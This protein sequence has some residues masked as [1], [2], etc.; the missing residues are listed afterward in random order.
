MW[1]RG[2]ALFGVVVW[3]V[4]ALGSLLTGV[5]TQTAATYGAIALFAA[6]ALGLG[7]FFER[8]TA[9]LLGASAVALVALGAFSGWEFGVW[10][11]ISL[12]LILPLVIAAAL[13]DAAG[14]QNLAMKRTGRDTSRDRTQIQ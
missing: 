1:A 7:W 2:F 5:A 14:E 10:L 4:I 3:I 8:T 11:L 12:M 9:I 13:F 6:A